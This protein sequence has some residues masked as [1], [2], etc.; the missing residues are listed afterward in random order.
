[1]VGSTRVLGIDEIIDKSLRDLG[2]QV[3]IFGIRPKSGTA[4]IA[5][6]LTF[7]PG[8]KPCAGRSPLQSGGAPRFGAGDGELGV[9]FTPALPERVPHRPLRSFVAKNRPSG[10][11][12][13]RAHKPKNHA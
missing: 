1:V 6:C 13:F 8:R 9:S 5:I 10:K 4:V 2:K 3:L 12:T 11:F 7:G